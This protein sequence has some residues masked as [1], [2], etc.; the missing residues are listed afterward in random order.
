[1][2]QQ[3]KA[4]TQAQ[5]MENPYTKLIE[6]EQQARLAREA[7]LKARDDTLISAEERRIQESLRQQKEELQRQGDKAKETAQSATSFS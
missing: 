4:Q 7:E 6:Q 5:V 3:L 1:M 2:Q